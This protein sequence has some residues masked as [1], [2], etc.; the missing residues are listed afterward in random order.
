[1]KKITFLTLHLGYGG[2]ENAITTLANSLNSDYKI[3]I[4]SVYKR[5]DTPVFKLN[6]NVKINYLIEHAD[7]KNIISKNPLK[8]LKN[9]FL[10]KHNHRLELKL[11]KEFIMNCDSDIIISTNFKYNSII[12]KYAGNSLKIGWDHSYHNNN[13]KYI[14][15]IADSSKDLDY[16]VLITNEMYSCFSTLL[17]GTNCKCVHIPNALETIPE[18]VSKLDQKNII[19]IGKLSKEKAHADLVEV[20]KYV[21]LKYPDWKL[22]IIGDGT[23]RESVENQIKKYK[24]EDNVILHGFRDKKY[25]KKIMENS[26]ICVVSSTSE[27]FG[28][29]ILEAFSYG[30]P[31][32]AFDAS[33]G[34]KELISN[35]WDGYLVSDLDKDRMTKKIIDL[36]KNDNRRIIMG[37]NARKKSLKY[38]IDEI[39]QLWLKIIEQKDDKQ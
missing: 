16:L 30:I 28:I 35:N 12:S 32:V 38:T 23:E 19:S 17:E 4:I 22:N 8:I 39:K 1:M 36:I 21:S 13:Q 15:K 2:I 11:V 9:V 26:S 25:I 37:S 31:C 3:E 18:D 29:V 33:I 5:Y 27:A 7:N 10:K 6:K 20:F 34:A 24:L 14:Q